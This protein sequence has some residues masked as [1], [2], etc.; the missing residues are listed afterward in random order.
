MALSSGLRGQGG[1]EAAAASVGD[2]TLA[3]TERAPAG[4]QAVEEEKTTGA[5][6]DR[7][8][9]LPDIK[10]AIPEKS[11]EEPMLPANEEEMIKCQKFLNKLAKQAVARAH[12]L[13]Q[14]EDGLQL[15]VDQ[16]RQLQEIAGIWGELDKLQAESAQKLIFC[17]GSWRAC[18][19]RRVLS[20]RG[21]SFCRRKTRN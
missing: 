5:D 2:D 12:G 6:L 13:Q 7:S 11:Q 10:Q 1:V 19:M 21:T 4:P 3:E 18:K 16:E 9:V 8:N 17:R 15:N 14:A 20:R